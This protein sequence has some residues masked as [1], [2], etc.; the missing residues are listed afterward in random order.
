MLIIGTI[1]K[2]AAIQAPSAAAAAIT[3]TF[4]EVP[5]SKFLFI[6]RGRRGK[7]LPGSNSSRSGLLL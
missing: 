3:T 1:A 4:T 5:D 7:K 2:T 6:I